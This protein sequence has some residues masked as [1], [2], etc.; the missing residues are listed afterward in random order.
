MANVK[1]R[2]IISFKIV[3]LD[4]NNNSDDDDNS[5]STISIHAILQDNNSY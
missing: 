1:I 4:D 5:N 2:L 3:N